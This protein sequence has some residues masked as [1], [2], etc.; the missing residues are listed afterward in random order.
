[1]VSE[2]E[3][4]E[5]TGLGGAA[6]F[7]ELNGQFLLQLRFQLAKAS[8]HRAGDNTRQGM[9]CGTGIHMASSKSSHRPHVF[10]ESRRSIGCSVVAQKFRVAS[11]AAMRWQPLGARS[12]NSSAIATTS[13]PEGNL[14]V[15]DADAV[16]APLEC[17]ET[18]SPL[19]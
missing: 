19:H 11:K 1:M 17:N 10:V 9:P 16:A 13:V 12:R 2:H 3:G 15:H 5:F 7:Y 8:R 6:L 18:F 4:W 14:R